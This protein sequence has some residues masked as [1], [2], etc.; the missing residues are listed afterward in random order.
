MAP[1]LLW[2][3]LCVCVGGA[4]GGACT[5]RRWSLK[6]G[7]ALSDGPGNYSVMGECVWVLQAPPGHRVLLSLS[8]LETE[9]GFD[10][11]FVFDGSAHR[12][13]LLA[14]LSGN[15]PP[16]PI[17]E[18]ASGQVGGATGGGTANGRGGRTK[19]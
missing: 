19:G 17:I 2:A 1:P 6:G 8:E 3:W 13:R 16:P 7:G 14:A 18:A 5:G 10:F 15:A 4:V 12:G 11:L 9:C